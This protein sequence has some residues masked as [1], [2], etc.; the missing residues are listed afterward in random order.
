MPIDDRTPGGLN[1]PLPNPENFL[2]EDV[3][4]LRDA[5]T[6]IE[7]AILARA[8]PLGFTPE[9]VANKGMA[10]GY[11]PL[12][13]TGIVP[14]EHLPPPTPDTDALAEGE[15]N[16]YFTN[17]RARAA[18]LPAT[19]SE[20]GV[21]RIGSGLVVGLDGTL[22]AL[23]GGGG[24]GVPAFNELLITPTV[25]GQTILEP[26][27]GYSVGQI[28]LLLNGVTLY[29]NG[30]DYTASDGVQ[31]ILAQG[32][33]TADLLLLRRW[34]TADNLPFAAITDKPTTLAGYGIT[35]AALA[36]QVV[37]KSGG[38]FD[39]PV[40]VPANASGSQV[41]RASEV[42][43]LAV[44]GVV[45]ASLS[46]YRT[47]AQQTVI[48]NTT[49]TINLGTAAR[50]FLVLNPLNS[51]IGITFTGGVDGDWVMLAIGRTGGSISWAGVTWAT[52]GGL[53]P[54]V[55]AGWTHLLIMRTGAGIR[56]FAVGESL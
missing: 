18:Q 42:L 23:G 10:N 17:A 47:P 11:A 15:L 1:F 22:S 32:V 21:V 49:Q 29:G 33:S 6:A 43:R 51:A 44:G 35:D 34:T 2:L 40:T 26:L 19:A 52:P 50:D 25:D 37:P 13:S 4:R 54:T 3:A 7:T 46:A 53:A 55:N 36:A 28:E 56:G 41:P 24:E 8:L 9:N 38:G 30:E 14:A 31:I 20:L 48:P 39:G 16:L 27:G 5:L 45:A 12:G